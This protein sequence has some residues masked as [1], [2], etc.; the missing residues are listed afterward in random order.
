[1]SQGRAWGARHGDQQAKAG[2]GT[3][4]T[5]SPPQPAHI[6]SPSQV[7]LSFPESPSAPYLVPMD[8]RMLVVS[9]RCARDRKEV[10]QTPP[11]SS[12][13]RGLRRPPL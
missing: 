12:G 1:M 9:A 4:S 13:P 7:V 6:P 10:A 8:C 3:G 2:E 5:L 11:A